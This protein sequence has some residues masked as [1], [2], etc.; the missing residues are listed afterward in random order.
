[1]GGTVLIAD[2]NVLS[3]ADGPSIG[4]SMSHSG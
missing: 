4:V 1:M 3:V 2:G